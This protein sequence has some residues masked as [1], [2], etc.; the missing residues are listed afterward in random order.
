MSDEGIEFAAKLFG[1]AADEEPEA[2]ER[3]TDEDRIA[4]AREAGLPATVAHRLRGE[5]AEELKQDASKLASDLEPE[6]PAHVQLARDV[7][8]SLDRGKAEKN[9][10]ILEALHPSDEKQE[11]PK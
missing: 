8:A 9:R 2:T 11:E 5:T 10:A 6:V 3:T 4:A 1:T 7:L